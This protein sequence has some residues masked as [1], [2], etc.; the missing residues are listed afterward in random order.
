[1]N[2]GSDSGWSAGSGSGSGSGSGAGA[3]SGSGSKATP[4]PIAGSAGGFE[5]DDLL[6]L[7][8]PSRNAISALKT[9][10]QR[11]QRTYPCPARRSTVVTT[12]VSVHFGQTVNKAIVL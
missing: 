5:G 7:G 12:S 4:A 8:S 11:P 2:S 1:M 10:A 3:G 6:A 9:L